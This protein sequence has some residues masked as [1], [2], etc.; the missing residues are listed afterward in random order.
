VKILI[1]ILVAQISFAFVNS[2]D[3]YKHVIIT[4]QAMKEAQT[5]YS[6]R[7]LVQHRNMR[8][9]PSTIVTV[10]QIMVN[11]AGRDSAE[12]VRNFIKDANNKWGAEYFLLAG[13]ASIVPSRT[14]Y[15]EWGN[16]ESDY[17][18]AAL[19]GTFFN[20]TTHRWGDHP[21][22][23]VP[24][25][26]TVAVGR[27]P[28]TDIAQMSN[29]VYKVIT[30]ETSELSS[31]YHKRAAIW[32]T[33]EWGVGQ[34][35]TTG[36]HPDW[37]HLFHAPGVTVH[38]ANNVNSHSWALPKMSSG[39]YGYFLSGGHGWE[40]NSSTLTSADMD[41]LS[42]GPNF[43]FYTS[44]SCF[45]GK[46]NVENSFSERILAGNRNGGAFAAMLNSE[47]GMAGEI[48]DIQ[49]SMFYQYFSQGHERLGPLLNAMRRDLAS[50]RIRSDQSFSHPTVRWT[51]YGYTLFGDP[52]T[53]WRIDS[54]LDSDVPAIVKNHLPQW[55]FA[56]TNQGW[57]SMNNMT[58]TGIEGAYQ[59]RIDVG[60]PQLLSPANLSI[61]A[62]S[63]KYAHIIMKNNT[64]D[65]SA[66]LFWSSNVSGISEDNS[67]RFAIEPN[68]DFVQYV[69][70]LHPVNSWTGVINSLRLDPVNTAQSGSVEIRSIALLNHGLRFNTDFVI[71]AKH[72]QQNLATFNNQTENGAN[73]IQSNQS[74]QDQ[75]IWALESA[76]EGA[77]YIVHNESK[78]VL[79][80][81]QFSV[82]DGGNIH[83]WE[84]GDGI[85]NVNQ[86]W[87]INELADGTHRIMAVNS[88]KV[89]EVDG[90]ANSASGT[91]VQQWG[92]R[93]WNRQKWIFE[94]PQIPVVEEPVPVLVQSQDNDS[95]WRVYDVQ[96]RFVVQFHGRI[97]DAKHHI[98][99]SR[100]GGV[101]LMTHSGN[102]KA[103]IIVM[104]PGER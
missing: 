89:I 47:S 90:D 15:H 94:T 11:Y 56:T 27:V 75:S 57:E 87:I 77:V 101:Y 83:L 6:L 97:M 37:N 38:Q 53:P 25:E 60:D 19:N 61:T 45:S 69:L 82:E 96:G 10:N 13:K 41:A 95:D 5:D 78:K 46:Y 42:N 58:V 67:L 33:D 26:P 63:I 35:V 7:D 81:A 28:V 73:I 18:Y 48:V 79:D 80:V 51:I 30:Y 54:S 92:W 88:H 62:D 23:E 32:T 91:N 86:K 24:T 76:G 104:Q 99:N 8:N 3:S 1:I 100:P 103:Q 9:M 59:L 14:F 71:L 49:G 12:K 39:E 52:A 55:D 85:D 102:N 2:A 72:T 93:E 65:S 20:S 34:F 40:D 29:F 84:K 36:Q 68:S 21:H 98:S 22:H 74:G 31:S 44:I 64:S 50:G 4:S 43:F 70:P 16:S 17:Y 66:Q